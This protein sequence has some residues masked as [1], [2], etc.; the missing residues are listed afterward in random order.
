MSG[1]AN[2]N[3]FTTH[4]LVNMDSH[5][6]AKNEVLKNHKNYV[7]NGRVKNKKRSR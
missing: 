7:N 1:V 6:Y 2:M 3:V 5:N 4:Y